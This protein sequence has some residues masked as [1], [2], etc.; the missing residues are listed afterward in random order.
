MVEALARTRVTL[1]QDGL[2]ERTVGLVSQRTVGVQKT[3]ADSSSKAPVSPPVRTLVGLSGVRWAI[4]PCCAEAQPER[5]LAHDEVRQDAGWH[6]QRRTTMLA[7]CFLGPLKRPVGEKRPGPHRVAA[8]HDL[9]GRLTPT[10][11]DKCRRAGVHRVGAAASPPSRSSASGAASRGRMRRERA[12][13]A[14]TEIMFVVKKHVQ[15]SGSPP[16]V[17]SPEE[18]E[19]MGPTTIGESP[20]CAMIEP[21]PHP[22]V[23]AHSRVH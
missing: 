9:R 14:A 3:D 7:P 12:V 2:P 8:A 17:L 18:A 22:G 16:T 23:Q 10:E 21:L 1:W 5:G 15:T 11:I 4:A 19:D 20:Q 13:C 6:H